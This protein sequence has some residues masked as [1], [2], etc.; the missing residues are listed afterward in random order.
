MLV[1]SVLLF[2]SL[3]FGQYLGIVFQGSDP[4]G[5]CNG[6]GNSAFVVNNSTPSLWYCNNS[7]AGTYTK[8]AGSAGGTTPVSAGGTGLTS[9]TSGGIP[10]F[11]STTTMASSGALA[12]G[13]FVLGGGAGSSPTTSFSVVPPANGGFPVYNPGG[14]LQTA[15]TLHAVFGTCTL[16]TNCTVTLT[17]SAAFTSATSYG[18]GASDFTGANAVKIVQA[19]G[20]L[21]ITGTGTDVIQYVCVGT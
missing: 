12:S 7:S 17:G 13:Q 1:A 16:G 9:G 8:I 4:S 2:T 10:Y 3:G 15:S 18:C 5:S 21:T 11:N 6:P 19:A 20:S 14:T